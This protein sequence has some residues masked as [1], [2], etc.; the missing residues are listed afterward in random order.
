[1]ASGSAL[2]CENGNALRIRAYGYGFESVFIES[3]PRA[4]IQPS[5]GK[6][7]G[8]KE[9]WEENEMVVKGFYTLREHIRI[10]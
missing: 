10:L 1:M 5:K 4:G 2:V 3:I 9:S 6:R 7:N 8:F